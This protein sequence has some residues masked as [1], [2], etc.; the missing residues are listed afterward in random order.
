[1]S[2]LTLENVPALQAEVRAL[3]AELGVPAGL[4]LEGGYDLGALS[5]SLCDV[6]ATFAADDAP[7]RPELPFHPL[8]A[9]A[10]RRLAERWPVLAS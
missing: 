4:V 8:A 7:A 2:L 9:A 10:Q 6:L 5:R 1:M 3:A